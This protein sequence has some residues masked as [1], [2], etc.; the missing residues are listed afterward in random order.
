[1]ACCR[2]A[3][4]LTAMAAGSEGKI[5]LFRDNALP[6][7]RSA[8]AR[9]AV[10][11]GGRAALNVT[12]SKKQQQLQDDP[13]LSLVHPPANTLVEAKQPF[14]WSPFP[15]SPTAIS[16]RETHSVNLHL[17]AIFASGLFV[18]W[19]IGM[20]HRFFDCHIIGV[21]GR[22]IYR[23][24]DHIAEA[25]MEEHA[26]NVAIKSEG[27]TCNFYTTKFPLLVGNKCSSSAAKRWM[28]MTKEQQEDFSNGG[29]WQEIRN[30]LW[31]IPPVVSLVEASFSSTR[32]YLSNIRDAESTDD[33]IDRM[34]ESPP[35]LWFESESFHYER[36]G[37]DKKKV[38]TSTD[39][40][41]VQMK[42]WKDMSSWALSPF[43]KQPHMNLKWQ[44]RLSDS[45]V[46]KVKVKKALLFR[47]KASA[48]DYY[49]QLAFFTQK[50][51]G[52]DKCHKVTP[53]FALDG[54]QVD[55]KE[56]WYNLGLVRTPPCTRFIA[57]RDGFGSFVSSF[58]SL[59]V[60]WVATLL[61][62]TVPYRF[63]LESKCGFATL[64]VVKAVEAG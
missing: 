23:L 62:M 11:N 20:C 6:D 50:T 57:V 37:D 2:W 21:L 19:A 15:Y 41:D 31:C 39:R 46:V 18:V 10:V 16:G 51:K 1:M 4:I 14:R 49:D 3:V 13:E 34:I 60:F 54:D 56:R 29:M 44:W 32:R 24:F 36:R 27:W 28:A 63:W 12:H 5:S 8:A 40:W 42:A 64:T 35:I 22:S 38:V 59:G 45:P 9:S 30:A 7:S 55:G 47:N 61:G 48:D 25:A 52:K 26:E 17:K 53:K 58:V 43:E 33:Y